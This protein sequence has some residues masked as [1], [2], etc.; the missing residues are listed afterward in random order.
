[1]SKKSIDSIVNIISRQKT[2]INEYGKPIIFDGNNDT[3]TE[4]V[5]YICPYCEN[6]MS[7][8]ISGKNP[9]VA[10][11]GKCCIC[12]NLTPIKGVYINTN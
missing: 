3:Y 7:V 2:E 6:E 12:N 1:M 4:S 8:N 10:L 5:A 9:I 11:K